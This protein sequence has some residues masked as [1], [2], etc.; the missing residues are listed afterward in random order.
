MSR[1]KH[2]DPKAIRAERRLR[3]PR[4][5]RGEGDLSLRRR[6]GRH[7]RD[8]GVVSGSAPF[9]PAS[10]L[11]WPRIIVCRPR[12]GFFHPAARSAVM[13]VLESI[14]VE[15]IYGLR[16]IEM[17]HALPAGRD[18]LPRFGRLCV[19]GRIVL[20]EQPLPPWRLSGI[21]AAEDASTLTRN[22]AILEFHRGAGFTVV[23]WPGNSLRNFMIIEVLLHEFGHHILQQYKGKRWA[24]IARPC[25]HEVFA[26]RHVERARLLVRNR[27]GGDMMQP[28]VTLVG[29]GIETGQC[30]ESLGPGCASSA[31]NESN[32]DRATRSEAESCAKLRFTSAGANIGEGCR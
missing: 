26:R 32:L 23:E 25:D 22:G 21:L 31:D 7:L 28:A 5:K 20:Y 27:L 1:S 24:R 3:A 19:P 18:V 29:D 15:A 16:A 4:D 10:A 11:R 8:M 30:W 17:C 14:G 13:R 2:T 9:T 6:Q 12:D